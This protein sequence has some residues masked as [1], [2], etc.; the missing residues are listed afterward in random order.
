VRRRLCDADRRRIKQFIDIAHTL[1]FT[2]DN[3]D[4]SLR[5]G[6]NKT[7]VYHF[8]SRLISIMNSCDTPNLHFGGTPWFT[9]DELDVSVFAA[10]SV[11]S[12]ADLRRLCTEDMVTALKVR[13][14]VA[15]DSRLT[16]LHRSTTGRTRVPGTRPRRRA[17]KTSSC[18][19]SSP[20]IRS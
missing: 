2:E 4:V 20:R 15:C 6:G 1:V 13:A 19:P 8:V 5:I 11:S 16:L 12:A 7:I 10:S 14:R 3:L 17:I 18:Y 9:R